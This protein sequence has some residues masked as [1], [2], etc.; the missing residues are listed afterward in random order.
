MGRMHVH[1]HHA[2]G[3]LGENID[4]LELGNGIAERRDI[5][6]GFRQSG[7]CHSRRQRGKIL[8]VGAGRLCCRQARLGTWRLIAGARRMPDRRARRRLQQAGGQADLALG[9]KLASGLT[10]WTDY[11]N[12]SRRRRQLIFRAHLAQGAMQGAVEKVMHHAPVTETH[13]MLGRVDVDVNYR[14]IDLQKQHK[15]RMTTVE[16]HIAI[17]LAHRVGHQFVAH[18]API[19]IEIL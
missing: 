1:H 3:I 11:F 5:A 16:Q 7:R 10:G 15:G 8:T 9:A 4:A 12:R 17:G 19:H 13:F 2:L 6:L 14:R 18:H